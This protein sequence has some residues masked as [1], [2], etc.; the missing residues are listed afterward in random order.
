MK[1]ALAQIN[2]RVGAIDVRMM[3]VI[4]CIPVV[5]IDGSASRTI[6]RADAASDSGSP[7]VRTVKVKLR[8]QGINVLRP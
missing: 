5:A 4:A 2:T 6:C 1:I 7:D 3:S 8:H